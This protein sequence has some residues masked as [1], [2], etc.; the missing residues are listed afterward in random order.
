MKDILFSQIGLWSVF[1]LLFIFAAMAYF[2]YKMVK[3]SKADRVEL[4]TS[5]ANN[6]N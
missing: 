4:D 6:K 5:E 3:L 2:V 1:T